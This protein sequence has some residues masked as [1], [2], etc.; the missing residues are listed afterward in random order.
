[1]GVWDGG[2]SAT[3]PLMSVQSELWRAG[4][5]DG[6]Q[7]RAY[8]ADGA[9][10]LS[11]CCAVRA[12]QPR[13]RSREVGV[14]KRHGALRRKLSRALGVT[15]QAGWRRAI[16]PAAEQVWST[17][18]YFVLRCELMNL[19]RPRA[20]ALPLVMMARDSGTFEALEGELSRATGANYLEVLSRVWL[21]EAGVRELYVADG[22]DGQPAYCQWLVRR[23]EERLLHEHAPG[24][25]P[26]LRDGEV[27]VEGAY[28]FVAHR[29]RG[30]MADG[31]WQLL[32][33]ARDEGAS[34]ALTV[35][36]D[37][38][39]ASLRGCAAVG[40]RPDHVKHSD[41]RFGFARSIYL[42][43]DATARERWESATGAALRG[44]QGATA[45]R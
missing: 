4:V 40:F 18:D 20:A 10:L 3:L 6:W 2:L 9:S 37:D 45:G 43:A 26:V 44:A 19:Q 23:G 12:T 7:P 22:E 34:A 24:R 28:T 32:A 39:V 8:G 42:P 36:A 25:F 15:R 14:L 11:R 1:M 13:G 21:C 27:L 5:D 41:C 33:R 29:R 17:R 16:G 30:A 31:M 38:N 35:V